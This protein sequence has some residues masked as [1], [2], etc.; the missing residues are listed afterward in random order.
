M[1][2]PAAGARSNTEYRVFGWQIA[3][4]LL[5]AFALRIE[6]VSQ[7][8]IDSLS[9]R[10][11]STAMMADNLPLNGW[12]PLWPEVSWTGDQ[13]GYQGREFQFL[14]IF[15]AI[16]NKIFG[17]SDWSGRLMA[18]IFGMLTTYSLFR[19][20]SILFGRTQGLL[21]A[22]FYAVLPGAIIIDSSYLPDPGMLAVQVAS[23]WCLAEAVSIDAKRPR[24]WFV[25][26][27]IGG[28][29][30]ILAKLPAASALPAA[31]YLIWSSTKREKR[32]VSM[33]VLGG[34]LA[35]ASI[36]I[37]LYYR[38]AIYLGTHYPPFHIAGHGWLWDEGFRSFWDNG[39]YLSSFF[40]HITTW[41]WGPVAFVFASLGLLAAHR[42]P[43]LDKTGGAG[44]WFLEFWL[45]GCV[46]FYLVAALELV[47]NSWNLH[48]F[49]PVIAALAARGCLAMT[50]S[51]ATTMMSARV[52]VVVLL[53]L[54]LGR[55]E[56]QSKKAPGRYED[57]LLGTHLRILSKPGDLVVVSGSQ[58]GSPLPIYYSRRK[59][60]LLPT[61]E[62]SPD[63]AMLSEDGEKAIV[64]VKELAARG[65]RWL[66]IAKYSQDQNSPPKDFRTHYVALMEYLTQYARHAGETETHVIY[67]IS[68]LSK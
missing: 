51:H 61:P 11:A 7:P 37:I 55:A 49:S 23:L 6:F 12:N 28:T 27:A 47:D 45:L 38:W 39:F 40:K 43:R 52:F 31:C 3:I 9:W 30:A 18:A 41:L 44:T 13:P 26:A 1:N 15:S 29:A 66:G 33:A 50:P 53:T 46:L 22:L 19:L 57:Y 35:L 24:L 34:T 2:N 62:M 59:G 54:V 58:T 32:F 4:V 42:T 5:V 60:W 36:P 16:L 48:V 65:G 63:Y 64:A 17:W 14:T 10:E 67:D 25:L 21:S 20:V 56:I 8:L 68:P